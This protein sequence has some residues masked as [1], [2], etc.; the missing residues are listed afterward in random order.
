MS[1]IIILFIVMLVIFSILWGNRTFSVKTLNQMIYHMVVPC[2]G[3]DEGIFKDWFLNCAPPAFLTTLIGVFLLY[4]TPLVFL[5]D[6]QGICI[7]ILI[8]GTLLYAL[9]NYQIITYVFD[10]V[11]TSKLYEEHYVDP[12]NV[13]LEFKEKRNLI[14]IY[15]ESIENIID[16]KLLNIFPKENTLAIIIFGSFGTDRATYNSDIDIAWIPTKKVPITELAV[17]TQ[18]LRNVLDIDVDLKIVTDNYTVELRKNIFEGDII[19]Q[20]KEF[21]DYLNNF[22]IENSDVIDILNWMDM[23]G[24]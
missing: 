17:K 9:I 23:H 24:S 21:Q 5:F 18:S 2:D 7:T 4:K 10:M 11:R 22:Y 6:Y 19:Y 20:S 12:Q 16:N 15:L 8:L 3:T 13:E 1:L 14:H